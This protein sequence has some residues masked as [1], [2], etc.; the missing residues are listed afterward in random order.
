VA[1]LLAIAKAVKPI[2]SRIP[3]IVRTAVH[4]L[5]RIAN[6]RLALVTMLKLFL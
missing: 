2:A 1:I 3:L 4:T 6:T 5:C